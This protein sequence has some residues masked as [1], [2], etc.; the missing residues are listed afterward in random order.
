MRRL[1]ID[2]DQ[3]LLGLAFG[4][5]EYC[6][7]GARAA[8]FVV[9][10]PFYWQDVLIQMDRLG[11]GSLPVVLITA[12]FTG[13]VLSLQ[14]SL[15]LRQFGSEALLGNLVAVAMV[16]EA[17]PVL[18]ALAAAGRVSSGIAAELGT[19][20]VTEQIDAL[21][22]IGTDP[23]KKLVTPRLLAGVIMLPVL[24]IIADVVGI[25]GGLLIAVF[26][27][28]IPA[29]T[30]LQG[31]LSSMARNG[32]LFGFFPAIFLSSILKPLVS[33][34]IIALTGC[35]HGLTVEGGA[36]AVGRA[37]TRA[38]VMSFILLVLAD[39]AMTELLLELLQRDH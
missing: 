38:M 9:G 20:K 35:Y 21:E 17:G 29:Q 16:R 7:L 25:L 19:M 10:R 37:A 32:F 14:T 28:E 22:T 34:A 18:G 4:V 3:R 31:A 24:I 5:Q 26:K 1:L 12:A 30:Y 2:I 13:M 11:V 8:R 15:Q 6:L 36:E 33:G 23:I 39:Y 27:V